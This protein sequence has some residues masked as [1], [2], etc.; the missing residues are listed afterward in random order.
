[1]NDPHTLR[2]L[3]QYARPYRGRLAWAVV[4][5]L[6]YAAGSAGLAW[7]IRWIFDDVLRNQEHLAL[8]G[9][10]IVGLYL[11]KGLGSY[12]ST[13]L[14][15][16]VGQRVVTD[17]RNDLYRHILGQS[18][19]FFSQRTT[20][21]LM[22]RLNNDVG[23]VQ[24]AVSETAGDLARES[25]ALV[26]YGALLFYYDAWLAVFCFISAPLI[27]YPLIRLGQRVRRT[28]RRSQEALEQLSHVSVEAFTGHRI[29]KAFGS[30]GTEA[31]K[32][33]RAGDHL[34]RTNMKVTAALSSL[35]PLMEVLGG[36][37]MAGALWYGSRE[38]ATGQLSLGE[39]TS[40]IAALFLMYGP[41]KKLSRVNA[42]LQQA[43]A[44]SERI[45]E[46]LD[47]HTE[48]KEKP[49]A[50]ALAPFRRAIEFRD[51]SFGY[52]E[53]NTRTLRG[54]SFTVPAGQMVAIVGRSG[55]GKTTLVNLLPRFYDV[56][57]GSILIDGVDIRDVTLAS[58]RSQ[59]G[60]V[61]QE[62]VLFDDTVASNIAYGAP[63][64][65]LAEIESAARVAHAHEFIS[66]LP[67]LYETLIGERGQRLSGGQ[68]Q[69]VAIARAL[70]KNAPILILDEATSAL[71]TE[72]ERLVQD[73]LANLMMNRTSFVIAHRLSTIRRADAIVVIERG[74]IVEVG[75]HDELLA[76]PSGAYAL[77]YQ[78]QLL[79]GRKPERRMVPS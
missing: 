23:Q 69:R 59:I 2:R 54:V 74:R 48:V 55:A 52:E 57:A 9:W 56:S 30:E 42:S 46:M 78:M 60:I 28:T 41:A 7:L 64:A 47:T 51:V 43:I 5:M 26:A 21:Q 11:L 31:E 77:L 68:R 50:P 14:M 36:V 45:F 67:R 33:A 4:G 24:Q 20:G 3:F 66:A 8:T 13:Y 70:L 25:I 49:G 17:L 53:L 18:A 61:T 1:M 39:F 10:T 32:F 62:T 35:P 79:E 22:S 75:R 63:G 71:D 65:S 29:V 76:R 58:L 16:S 19:S 44:A 38:I 37:A 12:A 73:A 15:A 27:V 34:Y 40:F 72:A 6:V